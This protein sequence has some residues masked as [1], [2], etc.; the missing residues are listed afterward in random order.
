MLTRLNIALLVNSYKHF[1]VNWHIVLCFTAF[2]HSLSCA[3]R[4][5]KIRNEMP[6]NLAQALPVMTCIRRRPVQ[7]LAWSPTTISREFLLARLFLSFLG[8]IKLDIQNRQD[9]PEWV[10]SL[11][12]RPTQHKHKRQT[13]M[14]LAGIEPAIPVIWRPQTARAP[15]STSWVCSPFVNCETVSRTFQLLCSLSSTRWTVNGLKRQEAKYSLDRYLLH[16]LKWLYETVYLVA[17][18]C[19]PGVTLTVSSRYAAAANT[20]M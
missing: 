16:F 8:H 5:W 20:R 9:S 17:D 14:L 1:F 4:T 7:I 13:S 10:I 18:T 12:Q 11:S 19:W 2:S 15:G 6:N 3:G